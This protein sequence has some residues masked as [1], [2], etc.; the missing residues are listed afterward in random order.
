[1]TSIKR[2]DFMMLILILAISA[3]GLIM[4]SSATQGGVRG[5]PG[6]YF[7]NR[8]LIWVIVGLITFLVVSLFDAR[9]IQ[10]YSFVLYIINLILLAAVL[11]VGEQK[12][13]AQRWIQIGIFSLQPS[14]TAKVFLLI[15]FAAYFSRFKERR[16]E[17]SDAI[18]SFLYLLPS[19]LLVLIQPDLGTSV[20][21]VLIWFVLLAAAG[22]RLRD[23]III[24]CVFMLVFAGAVYFHLLK[25]Y[26]IKRLTVFINP[27]SDPTEAGYNITQAKIAIGSGGFTGK[28]IYSG[29]QSAL[30]FVP[31]RHTDFI[32]SVI[33]EE[34]GFVGSVFLL[35]L[36][37]LLTAR[38]IYIAGKLQSFFLRLFCFG[39]ASVFV[40]HI[41]VNVGMN[42]GIMP[43]TGLPLPLVSYGGSFHLANMLNLG[44]IQSAWM[45]RLKSS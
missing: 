29:T 26:Q 33:G 16:P 44:I 36:Y 30:R 25:D 19:V 14:E 42:L 35:L 20:V 6:S 32:F 9:K 12:L 23:L 22:A 13:G 10:H 8:Q 41:L 4:L 31:E 34:T 18:V 28:G 37:F 43:I 2:F 15:F 5:V 38:I 24:V 3:F 39:F 27:E 7:V 1:M 17:L 11:F 40:F 45:H 21:L